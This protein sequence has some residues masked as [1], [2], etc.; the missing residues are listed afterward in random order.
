MKP[1]FG[2]PRCELPDQTTRGLP[3]A[4]YQACFISPTAVGRI[5]CG[6]MENM[7]I[8]KP[9]LLL[10]GHGT[11]NQGGLAEF[12][13]LAAQ[14]E[15]LA[16]DFEVE[17]CFLELAQ[18]DISTGVQ[19]LLSRE[20]ESLTVSP[21]LLF[22][23]GHAKRDIPQ[24]VEEALRAQGSGFRVQEVMGS[25]GWGMGNGGRNDLSSDKAA[26]G[27][28]AELPTI[29]NTQSFSNPRPLAAIQL[30]TINYASP[31]ECHD[32]IV[33]LS[34]Q[35]YDEAIAESAK[36]RMRANGSAISTADAPSTFLLLVG[37]GSS[38]PTAVAEMHRFTELRT[39]YT[40]VA[41]RECCF[42]AKAEPSLAA[43]LKMGA[44]SGCRRIVVQPHLLFAGQVLDEIAAAVEAQAAR[45]PDQ[46]WIVSQHL[47]PS[48]LAA[49]A[50]LSFAR[51]RYQ[52]AFQR[53]N[54]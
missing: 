3:V 53:R 13:A 8:R 22:A 48:P 49:E 12:R 31:L 18:P 40:P 21:V 51:S 20:I 4:I 19:K 30:L 27:G 5:G 16:H 15:Q 9:G 34:A 54:D 39:N 10:V 17:S 11:R 7:Q 32:K 36:R 2:I 1:V 38:E 29:A 25:G 47:G 23:A 41:Q 14:I 24:A 42:V 35:R 45:F 52:M 28:R 26:T 43:G 44:E 46:Q 50:V 33:E 6:L 37:R